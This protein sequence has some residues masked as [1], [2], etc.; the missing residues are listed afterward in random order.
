MISNRSQDKQTKVDDN[1]VTDAVATDVNARTVND[2]NAGNK[3]KLREL[4]T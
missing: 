3:E 1:A 2:V 4:N